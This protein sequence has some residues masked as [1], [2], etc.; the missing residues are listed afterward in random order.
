MPDSSSGYGERV[1]FGILVTF[2]LGVLNFAA[3]KAVLESGH[4]MLSQI[5]WLF[6]PLGGRLSLIVEFVMLLGAL[7]MVA[8]GSWGWA[9]LY[10]LYSAVNGTA[11]WLIF[12]GRV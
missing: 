12:S 8:S 6:Q 7:I 11:A 3:H 5:P 4:P 10:L 9:L 2:C 1:L